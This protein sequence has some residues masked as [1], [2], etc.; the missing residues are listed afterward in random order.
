MPT[1][2][3]D[4]PGYNHKG[5]YWLGAV[6]A[7]TNYMVLRGLRA[8]GAHE[9]AHEIG[10]NHLENVVK[11]FETTGTL[12]ENYAPE[13]A[14][15]GEPARKDFVGWTGLSPIA[16]L[17][18]AIFGL[19]SEAAR[20]EL[21]WDIRLLEEHGVDR[22]PFGLGATLDLRCASRSSP[23][24]EPIITAKASSPVKLVVTWPGGTRTI[25]LPRV[26]TP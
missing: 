1:L 2:S 12:W 13:S 3:A 19:R 6:W 26:N 22:Y 16:I 11:V 9:L 17:I 8:A 25:Q 5:G 15:P 23:E 7:P 4:D 24:E 21:T 20:N 10:M 14:S 18:E